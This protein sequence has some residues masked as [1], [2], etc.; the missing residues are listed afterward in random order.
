MLTLPPKAAYPM[1][2]ADH[3]SPPVRQNTQA[4]LHEHSVYS[5]ENSNVSF[6]SNR[7]DQLLGSTL[8]C[9]RSESE[10]PSNLTLPRQ[11]QPPQSLQISHIQQSSNNFNANTVSISGQRSLTRPERQRPR[12]SMVTGI[13][14]ALSIEEM[15]DDA[16][17]SR[18]GATGGGLNHKR[19]I[20]ANRRFIHNDSEAGDRY[21]RKED[22]FGRFR[23]WVVA[24]RIATCCFPGWCLRIC[25]KQ[26]SSMVQQAWREKVKRSCRI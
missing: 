1:N 4:Q 26:R 13:P 14:T 21:D 3:S 2:N 6:S 12:P 22:S 24:S 19:T 20:S 18:I 25:L 15:S 7:S 17:S 16:N 23:W 9:L 5:N 10:P 8:F 11:S